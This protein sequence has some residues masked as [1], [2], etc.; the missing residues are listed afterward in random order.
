MDFI[1]KLQHRFVN[2][3]RDSDKKRLIENFFSLSLLQGAN[4]LLPL[5]TLPYLVRVLGPEKYGLVMFAQAFIQFFAVFTDYGF[6]I[7]ATREISIYRKDGKKISQIFNSVLI[8]KF[9]LTIL[10]FLVLTIIV[11]NVNKFRNEWLIYFLTYG[12]VVGNIFFPVWFFQGIEMM[13]YISILNIISRAIFTISIFIFIRQSTDY[14]FVPL[15]NSLGFIVSGVIAFYL[16]FKRFNIKLTFPGFMNIYEQLKKGWHAFISGL[17]ISLSGR[18]NTIILGLLTNDTVVG[19]YVAAE[20]V[21]LALVQIFTPLFQTLYPFIIKLAS[22]SR[23]IAINFLNRIFFYVIIS[24]GFIWVVFFIFSD[25]LLNLV[26]GNDFAESIRVF[27]IFSP[28]LV[29]VPIA[30][31]FFYLGML[32]FNLDRYYST[33]YLIGSLLNIVLLY[34]FLVPVGL[35][36]RGAALA[37]LIKEILITFFAYIILFKKKIKLFPKIIK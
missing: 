7:S 13:R 37:G 5:I 28:Q 15:I 19:Y 8:V 36:A 12:M 26:L 14:I 6:N 3:K 31:I 24:S 10:S 34:I 25:P 21:F 33:L 23:E 17:A 29:I 35:E 16:A 1:K 22:N 11:F 18:A 2:L 27:K 20:K 4:Y 32:T 9:V 30:Y